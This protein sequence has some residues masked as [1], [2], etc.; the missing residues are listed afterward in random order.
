M[1]IREARQN[2][3]FTNLAGKLEAEERRSER[4][5]ENKIKQI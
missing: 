3:F 1:H 2:N 4:L 5:D